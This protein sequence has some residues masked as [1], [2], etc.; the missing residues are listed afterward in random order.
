ME[1]MFGLP[2]PLHRSEPLRRRSPH[3]AQKVAKFT[4][5]FNRKTTLA[6][7]ILGGTVG[8]ALVGALLGSV[9]VVLA[10]LWPLGHTLAVLAALP[11]LCLY[12]GIADLGLVRQLRLTPARQTTR[13]WQCSLGP[14]G[15]CLA[16]G[17]DLGTAITTRA[18]Y[19]GA[20]VI[21]AFALLSGSL[22]LAVAV[23]ALYGL[24]RSGL[25]AWTLVATGDRFVEY[26]QRLVRWH[27]RSRRAVGAACL[28]IGLALA[29]GELLAQKGLQL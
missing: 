5:G 8:G 23:M 6:I 1:R 22:P 18:P 2:R 16:W 27:S 20:L 4:G 28:S 25:V 11:L 13:A 9:G 17:A 24:T 12:V 3:A 7:H 19:Q 29:I 14:K 26:T 21:P 15:A 10:S